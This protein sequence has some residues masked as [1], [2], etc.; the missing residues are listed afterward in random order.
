MI[1]KFQDSITFLANSQLQL[2]KTV[3]DHS[4]STYGKFCVRTKMNDLLLLLN[5]TLL[6]EVI[7]KIAGN[8]TFLYLN[9]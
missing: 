2:L 9:P 6:F 5:K 8:K 1:E 3:R 7:K 4:F